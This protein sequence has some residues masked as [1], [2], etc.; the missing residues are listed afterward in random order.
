MAQSLFHFN[1]ST[2]SVCNNIQHRFAT[3][4]G[5]A[6]WV[7]RLA[8][9]TLGFQHNVKSVNV[10]LYFAMKSIN[11]SQW[12]HSVWNTVGV[13]MKRIE[14]SEGA[15]TTLCDIIWQALQWPIKCMRKHIPGRLL[16]NSNSV[17]LLFILQF[18]MAEDSRSISNHCAV[19]WHGI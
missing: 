1:I 10:L 14:A 2:V 19:F 3:E 9:A 11:S 18:G 13:P 15:A 12:D 7:T 8:S 4:V 16:C 5:S 6:G 17:I